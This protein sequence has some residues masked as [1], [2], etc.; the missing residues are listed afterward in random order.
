[1]IEVTHIIGHVTI[2][3]MGRSGV[4]HL[5]VSSG[6]AL[7]KHALML[8]NRLVANPDNTP[9]LELS[10]G[11]I[12]LSFDNDTWVVLCGAE[13]DAKIAKRPL[14]NGWRA[15]VNK[16]EQLT[17]RGPKKGMLGYLAVAGGI[18]GERVLNGYGTDLRA[19]F[20]GH[21]GRHLQTGDKLVQ[22]KAS[23]PSFSRPV[24]AVQRANDGILRALPGPELALFSEPSRKAFWHSSWQISPQR[25]RMGVRLSGATLTTQTEVNLRSHGVMPGVIQV[26]PSGEP[27]V[28]LADAQTTGGYPRIASV[29][30]ADLWKLAQT[31][32][33]VPIRFTHVSP[34]QAEDANYEWQQYFYRLS[35][36]MDAS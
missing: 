19:Q 7:D 26:P 10:S 18:D 23:P 21:H 32:T 5:G 4:A 28:L 9:A 22:M 2:Q 35:R 17:I 31:R 6:G 12:Q 20:G 16:G 11:E 3:D 8:A 13:Y 34:S 27:I 24:G 33:G 1:M 14:W 30:E 29:I 25:D 36:A 15:K